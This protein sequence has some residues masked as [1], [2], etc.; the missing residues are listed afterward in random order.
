MVLLCEVCVYV[1]KCVVDVIIL[2]ECSYFFIS[3]SFWTTE[4]G[5][6]TLA[7]LNMLKHVPVH[8]PLFCVIIPMRFCLN[9]VI[10]LAP[11]LTSKYLEPIM[12]WLV[13]TSQPYM[14]LSMPKWT[15]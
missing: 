6:L 7:L 8:S 10:T 3:S 11:I 14:G 9:Y 2:E 4:S 13:N 5:N 15:F 12:P 1:A